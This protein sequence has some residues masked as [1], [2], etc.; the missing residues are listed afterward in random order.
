MNTELGMM[1]RIEHV[2]SY[3]AFRVDDWG[4]TLDSNNVGGLV[5]M[6]VGLY[7]IDWNDPFLTAFYH[8]SCSFQPTGDSRPLVHVQIQETSCAHIVI[9][10]RDVTGGLVSHEMIGIVRV[11]ATGPIARA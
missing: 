9:C 10:L 2:T 1:P 4:N 6:G 5:D 7:G 8:V 11:G 3:I